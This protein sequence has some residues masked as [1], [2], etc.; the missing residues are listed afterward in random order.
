MNKMVHEA[1][2]AVEKGLAVFSYEHRDCGPNWRTYLVGGK[3]WTYHLAL[4]SNDDPEAHFVS[5]LFSHLYPG[6]FFAL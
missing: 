1:F 6:L 2:L 4:G 5:F 3:L